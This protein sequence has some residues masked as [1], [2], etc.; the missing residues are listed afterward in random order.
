MVTRHIVAVQ[1]ASCD[2]TRLV[3]SVAYEDEQHRQRPVVLWR[4]GNLGTDAGSDLAITMI[5]C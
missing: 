1:A 2:A 3:P 4:M 5:L